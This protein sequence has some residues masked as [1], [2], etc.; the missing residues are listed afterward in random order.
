L[1]TEHIDDLWAAAQQADESWAHLR[2]GPFPSRDAF[3]LTVTELMSRQGQPFWVVRPAESGVALGWLSYC[4]VYQA[5][6]SIE[7]GQIWFSPAL[8]QTRAA[9]E[10][11]YLLMDH[12]FSVLRY[13]RLVWRCLT[14]NSASL[15]A[16]ERLGFRPEGL[17][18]AAVLIKDRV[19][20]VA[21]HSILIAEWPQR[22]KAFEAWLDPSNFDASGRALRRLQRAT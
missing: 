19:C 9:T 20:D 7:I 11:I 17:W 5:D 22:R 6:R 21:W 16:A 13:R 14:T 15:R 3:A 10:A 1:A 2:F 18:R 4:D 12:A 8:Q